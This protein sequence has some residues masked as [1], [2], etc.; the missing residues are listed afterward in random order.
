[1]ILTERQWRNLKR[2][3]WDDKQSRRVRQHIGDDKLV[4]GFDRKEK[5][6]V[7]ARLCEVT[8]MVQFGVKTIPTRETAPVIW[9]HWLDDDGTPLHITD[10]RLVSYIQRCDLWRQG[11]DKYIKQFEHTEW[12][13]DRREASEEDDLGYIAKHLIYPR[14]KEASDK[15]AGFV[16]RS[17][18]ERKFF[19]PQKF[20][21][22]WETTH[23][24]VAA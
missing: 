24:R 5:H 21:A 23:D 20:R 17:P 11:A 19:E 2:V 1:M 7:I 9:K 22:S 8:V 3:R 15:M 13:E 12:L 18:L 14:V 4:V 10:P 16:N 6:W